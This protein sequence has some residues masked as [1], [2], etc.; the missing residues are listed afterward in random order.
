MLENVRQQLDS[1]VA[2]L[3]S[4]IMQDMQ[5]LLQQELVLAKTEIRED[6]MRI[7]TAVISSTF[8]LLCAV[9]ALV[10]FAFGA[11]HALLLIESMTPWGAYLITGA[12]LSI[13]AFIMLTIA[14]N[15]A[16]TIKVLPE[17]TLET[18]KENVEWIQQKM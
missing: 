16:T 6:M 15:Q 14:R 5:K 10:M 11:V 13:V 2:P 18:M 12:A 1:T 7:K 17:K 3:L 9:I 4:D 8:G